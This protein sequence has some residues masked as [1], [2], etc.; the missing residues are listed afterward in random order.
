MKISGPTSDGSIAPLAPQGADRAI[1]TSNGTDRT[2]T[3]QASDSLQ[4]SGEAQLAERLRSALSGAPAIR[5]DQVE[6]ARVKLEAGEI[7]SD[8]AALAA[9]MLDD[10]LEP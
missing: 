2:G 3:A 7:G 8:P 5:Q 1:G 9:R 6:A 4:L 10:M